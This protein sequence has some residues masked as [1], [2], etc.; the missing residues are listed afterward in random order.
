MV[1]VVGG[2]NIKREWYTF[3][4]TFHIFN[5]HIVLLTLSIFHIFCKQS[6]YTVKNKMLIITFFTCPR[7][8]TLNFK[9]K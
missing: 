7:K 6:G 4:Y 8:S 1:I 3:D 5:P 9:L 2:E